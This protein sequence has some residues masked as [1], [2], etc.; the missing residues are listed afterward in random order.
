MTHLQQRDRERELKR[1]SER[2]QEREQER[3]TRHLMELQTRVQDMV[4]QG[5][6]QMERS[7]SGHL[8]LQVVPVVQQRPQEGWC[9]SVTS[10]TGGVSF[11][12][13]Q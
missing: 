1:E 10:A 6:L 4:K 9:C 13:P 11:W 2:E 7:T 5:L 8:D 12:S 3:A